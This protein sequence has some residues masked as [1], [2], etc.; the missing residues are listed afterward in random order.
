MISSKFLAS[1]RGDT[2]SRRCGWQKLGHGTKLLESGQDSGGVVKTG[3][4]LHLI[5]SNPTTGTNEFENKRLAIAF[6]G[7]FSVN[8][9]V[10][11]ALQTFI[12]V[13]E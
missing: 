10:Y 7:H 13:Q 3:L 11:P 2:K 12:A 9:C 6:S 4:K 1:R 5:G 8:F